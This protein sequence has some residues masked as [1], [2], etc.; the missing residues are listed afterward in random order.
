[1]KAKALPTDTVAAIRGVHPQPGERRE[2]TVLFSDLVGL[3]SLTNLDE[4]R[5]F[6]SAY[7]NQ[8]AKILHQYGGTAQFLEDGFLAYFGFPQDHEDDV[9]R[10]VWAGMELMAFVQNGRAY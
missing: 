7:K 9:E 8:V 6:I 4:R 2:V 5:V 3:T 10:A 1:M